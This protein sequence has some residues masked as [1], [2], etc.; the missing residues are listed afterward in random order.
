M[1][2]MVINFLKIGTV[3]IKFG[4]KFGKKNRFGHVQFFSPAEFL[5]TAQKCLNELVMQPDFLI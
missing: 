1:D 4:P 2:L 5:N 3:Y